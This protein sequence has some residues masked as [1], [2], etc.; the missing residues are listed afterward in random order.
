MSLFDKWLNNDSSKLLRIEALSLV[1][2][3]FKL[4]SLKELENDC[5][6]CLSAIIAQYIHA[7]RL[8]E[9]YWSNS[10]KIPCEQIF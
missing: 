3:I 7:E 5:L 8:T 1:E 10:R 2:K 4:S 6:E 9:P